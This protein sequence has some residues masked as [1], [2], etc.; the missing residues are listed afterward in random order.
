MSTDALSA[1]PEKLRTRAGEVPTLVFAPP[2]GAPRRGAVLVLHGLGVSKEAQAKEAEAFARAGFVA[3]AYDAPHHGERRT[4]LVDEIRDAA[5]SRAHELVLG[6]V[7][8]AVDEIPAIVDAL[9]AEGHGRVGAAGVSMGAFIA[10]GAAAIEPRLSP[11]AS[12]LGAPDWAPPRSP[13][14]EAMRPLLARAPAR[15][16]ERFWPR[17]LFLANGRKDESVP[18]EPARRFVGALQRAYAASPE[19][20]VYREYP[21]STHFMRPEDWDDML[22]E[23]VAFFERFTAGPAET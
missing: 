17:P 10:L 21:E 9:E 7:A 23:L 8:E 4:P 13:V 19:R 12:I 6:V 3:V 16:L 14:T 5:G 1:T 20:L 22:R 11:V 15:H 18:P 2:P